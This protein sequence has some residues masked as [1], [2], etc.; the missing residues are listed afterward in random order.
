MANIISASSLDLPAGSVRTENGEIML[1]TI[2]QAYV[3]QDFENIV[4][5]TWP[6]G[7]RLLLGD[8]ATVADGFVDAAGFAAFNG[9]YSLGIN[10]FAV[11]KQDII[12]TADA[13]KAYVA[14][15][16]RSPAARASHWMSGVT[17]PTIS[18]TASA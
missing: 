18:R 15:A 3:Q 10:V 17:R 16:Q 8:I 14:R 7:T 9:V 1:R 13:A 11:G 12:D 6:D 5:K 2:G 4:L